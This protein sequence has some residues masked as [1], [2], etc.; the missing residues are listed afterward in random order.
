MKAKSTP[1]GESPSCV[2]ASG[3]LS[4]VAT[5]IM[6][7][8]IEF[9]VRGIL[10]FR[11]QRMPSDRVGECAKLICLTPYSECVMVLIQEPDDADHWHGF[12][13]VEGY[14][15]MARAE[16]YGKQMALTFYDVR[17]PVWCDEALALM[18]AK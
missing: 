17:Q 11:L 16:R 9:P 12:C 5:G 10:S 18:A 13:V 6:E 1:Q 8:D 14:R 4:P 7:G 3:H 2:H 15:F